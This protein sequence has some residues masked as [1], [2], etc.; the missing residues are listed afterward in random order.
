[1]NIF[2]IGDGS[3]T[4]GRKTNGFG[5]ILPAIFE[6]Q[7]KYNKVDK[8][9]IYSNSSEGQR[10]AKKKVS[11]LIY[12]TKT[13]IKID[14]FNGLDSFSQNVSKFKKNS[15]DCCFICT[16][17]HTHFEFSKKSL[18]NNLNTFVV[19]PFVLKQDHAQDLIDLQKQKKLYSY[20]DFHKRYDKQNILAKDKINRGEIGEILNINVSY[21]QKKINPEIIFKKWADKTNILQYLGV[22]Y[23]DLAYFLTNAKPIKVMAIGQKN[24]LK[25]KLNK[26]IYDSIQCIILWSLGR[27]KKFTQSISVNWIDPNCSSAMSSQKYSITGTKGTIF[28]EQK[29]RGFKLINDTSGISDINPDFCINYYRDNSLTFTGYGIESIVGFLSDSILYGNFK[30]KLSE[31]EVNRPTF[32]QALI[33]TKIIDSAN[34]SLKHKSKWVEII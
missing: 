8:V 18:K 4:T 15:F 23:I 31:L 20:V 9:F 19:K 26:N 27:S 25:N 34:L 11:N 28:C 32:S 2:I 29:E 7:K 21:S 12:L 13:Q 17:D 33:S 14:F 22:H 30:I 5:V 1:M 3:Y 16:P 10:Q 6:F 24:Y